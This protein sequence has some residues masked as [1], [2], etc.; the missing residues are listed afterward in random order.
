[1]KRSIYPSFRRAL[2]TM[3]GLCVLIS[4]SLAQHYAVTDLGLLPGGTFSQAAAINSLGQ[5]TGFAD[6]PPM[7]H[8]FLW[9]KAN[10]MQDL[11]ALFVSGASWGA[12]INDLG[13]VTGGSWID[14]VNN[15]AYLWTAATGMQSIVPV[16]DGYG[17]KSIDNFDQVAGWTTVEPPEA[18]VWTKKNGELNLNTLL[19]GMGSGAS[20]NNDLGQVVGYFQATDGNLHAFFWTL[21]S[22][23]ED[24]GE[25]QA[26]AINLFGNVVGVNSANHAFLWTRHNGMKDLGT[27]TGDDG[28]SAAAINFYGHIVGMSTSNSGSRAFLWNARKG[29]RDLNTLIPSNSGWTL[30]DASGINVFGS[31]VGTGMINGQFHAFMLTLTG[32]AEE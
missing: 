6:G 31:I 25:G 11:G 13:H 28:S 32:S 17:G 24:L 30:W 15:A 14:D 21:P 5:V 29:M 27:L 18:F 9:T 16:H 19:G 23:Y 26:T 7:S 1:L 3:A 2:L 8:A 4:P 12:S 22:G 10:G 20:G